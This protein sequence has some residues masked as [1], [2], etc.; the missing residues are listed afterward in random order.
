MLKA[1]PGRGSG[2]NTTTHVPPPLP[3]L[4]Y[5]LPTVYPQSVHIKQRM[6]RIKSP[7]NIHMN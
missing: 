6:G 3:A 4:S 7:Q 1:L 2:M 5:I